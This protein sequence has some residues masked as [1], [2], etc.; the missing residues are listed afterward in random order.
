MTPPDAR[1]WLILASDGPTL[2]A[3]VDEAPVQLE[4]D[5]APTVKPSLAQQQETVLAEL[6]ACY[7]STSRGWN[8][9]LR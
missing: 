3:L 8:D 2:A 9:L 7:E 4:L 6:R 1:P 5:A